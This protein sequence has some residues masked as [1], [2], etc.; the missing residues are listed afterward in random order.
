MT[1]LLRNQSPKQS[2]RAPI[3]FA[4]WMNTIHRHKMRGHFF[5]EPILIEILKKI[6][7]AQSC[8]LFAHLLLDVRHISKSMLGIHLFAKI[9]DSNLPRP[10]IY[11]GKQLSI[12]FQQ[13][14]QVTCVLRRIGLHHSFHDSGCAHFFLVQFLLRRCVN[15]VLQQTCFRIKIRIPLQPLQLKRNY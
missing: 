5:D 15:Q 13:L 8:R 3:P 2:L 4:K 6:I 14:G 7:I 1:G 12:Y 11:V 10:R 9:H